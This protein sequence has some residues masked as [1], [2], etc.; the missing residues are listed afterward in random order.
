[1]SSNIRITR[2]ELRQIIREEFMQGVP[3]FAVRQASDECIEKL[4]QFVK[5]YINRRAQSPVQAREMWEEASRTFDELDGELYDLI[6]S[7]LWSFIQNT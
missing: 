4:K 3:Q 6:E 5:Q 1:M 2:E 7:R